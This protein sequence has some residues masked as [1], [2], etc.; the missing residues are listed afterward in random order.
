MTLKVTSLIGISAV[1]RASGDKIRNEIERRLK[2]EE[3]VELDFS[4]VRYFASPF[5]NTAVAPLLEVHRIE[6]LQSLLKFSNISPVGKS[7]LNQA[8]DN[9]LKFY[10]VNQEEKEQI[11]KIIHNASEKK[12]QHE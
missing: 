2:L 4:E 8:I 3:H 1:S 12:N 10:S 9:A 7:L 11:N 5:F 6:K